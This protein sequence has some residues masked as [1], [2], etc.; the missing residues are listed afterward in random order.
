MVLSSYVRQLEREHKNMSCV[1]LMPNDVVLPDPALVD[2]GRVFLD[3]NNKGTFYVR[4]ESEYEPWK[5]VQLS[6]DDYSSQ[7]NIV[8][9]HHTN[10]PNCGG[11]LDGDEHDP[12]V[13]CAACGTKIWAIK[14]YN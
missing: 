6:S 8:Y 1:Y 11:L 3:D 4:T 2:I 14:T 13:R 5:M 7:N 9:M 10:C 12:S